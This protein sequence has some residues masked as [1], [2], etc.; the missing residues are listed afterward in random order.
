MDLKSSWKWPNV[1]FATN[2]TPNQASSFGVSPYSFWNMYLLVLIFLEHERWDYLQS[3]SDRA[4][5]FAAE[6][7]KLGRKSISVNV[8]VY[9]LK[10]IVR[11]I[12]DHISLI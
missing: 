6:N 5:V 9:F 12:I 7:G 10:C 3:A 1:A 2:L 11:L 8:Y 4:L